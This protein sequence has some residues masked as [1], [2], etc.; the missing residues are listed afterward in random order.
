MIMG[1]RWAAICG[2]Y[3]IVSV[4]CG[5]SQEPYLLEVTDS[6]SDTE[7][8]LKGSFP[9]SLDFEALPFFKLGGESGFIPRFGLW[10]ACCPSGCETEPKR[11]E[12]RPGE[13]AREAGEDISVG[14]GKRGKPY[15]IE[16]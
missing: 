9:L 8:P 1:V 2:F 16:G 15:N 10:E 4:K 7:S 13:V 6:S 3:I 5:T 14:Y 12:K 11:I